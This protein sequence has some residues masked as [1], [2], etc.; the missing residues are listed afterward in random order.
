MEQ[1]YDHIKFLNSVRAYSSVHDSLK[2]FTILF[3]KIKSSS[4][5]TVSPKMPWNLNKIS[6]FTLLHGTEK[7]E[8]NI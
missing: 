7:I 6:I 2:T 8:N 4:W 5:A 1:I 3:K